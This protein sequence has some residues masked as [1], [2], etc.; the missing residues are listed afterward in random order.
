MKSAFLT[1][2]SISIIFGCSYNAAQ[3][4]NQSETLSPKEEVELVHLRNLRYL[5]DGNAKGLAAAFSSNCLDLGGGPHG[6]GKVQ[7][8]EAYFVDAFSSTKYDKI[9]GKEIIELVD[10][11]KSVVYSYEE[12]MNSTYKDT[13]K[14]V[15]FEYLPGD[16][17]IWFPPTVGSPLHDGWASV[18]R[19]EKGVWKIIAID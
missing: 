1:I 7:F 14:K 19:K 13:G 15:G 12:I 10:L 4:H 9:R 8:D 2:L 3:L 17:L 6:T 11:E 5:V 18:Y 16:F